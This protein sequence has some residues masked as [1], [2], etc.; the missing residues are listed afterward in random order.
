MW[1]RIAKAIEA[2]GRV[3]FKLQ[4][5]SAHQK[6]SEKE[7]KL[8]LC[9]EEADK[10]AVAA[11]AENECQ[12]AL[13]EEREIFVKKCQLVQSS[14]LAMVKRRG[15]LL[16]E[17]GGTRKDKFQRRNEAII[18]IIEKD[19]KLK[20]NL[21]QSDMYQKT[22]CRAASRVKDLLAAREE[23]FPAHWWE[24]RTTRGEKL[25]LPSEGKVELT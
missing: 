3:N 9:N 16:D 23:A 1:E 25:K 14:L 8:R 24:P 10:R 17:L 4:K 19:E 2:K 15:Q 18:D 20:D 6:E 22:S 13:V 7:K 5:I 12:K 21:V 11:A